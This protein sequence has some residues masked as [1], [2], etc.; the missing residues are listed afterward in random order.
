MSDKFARSMTWFFKTIADVFF[1]KRYGHR[2]VVLETVAA[3]P[4]MVAGMWSHFESLRNLDRGHGTKIHRMLAE[5]E[6]ERKHLIFF[7]HIAK[8]SLLERII[9]II[10]QII[11][12]IFYLFMYIFFRGTAHRMVG[13]F[14]DEAVNSYTNYL[15]QI[16]NK[17][18]K[19]VSAPQ[20]AIDYYGLAQD[21][22]LK[23]LVKCVREDERKHAQV[24]HK[25]ADSILR[26]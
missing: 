10:A 22:K 20:I 16:E 7:L 25:Y 1:A 4:G 21:A 18:I 12:T 14:E 26:K 15:A 17:Q 13:Y 8:P 23:E 3:V 11:F 19:N 5:A 6:N 24:N 9:I 2:A